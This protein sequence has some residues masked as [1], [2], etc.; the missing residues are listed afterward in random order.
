MIHRVQLLL[1]TTLMCL[2]FFLVRLYVSEKAAII[3]WLDA[4]INEFHLIFVWFVLGRRIFGIFHFI[5]KPNGPRRLSSMGSTESARSE[6]K[7]SRNKLITNCSTIT[8]RIT[9]HKKKIPDAFPK[10]MENHSTNFFVKRETIAS[11]QNNIINIYYCRDR[12]QNIESNNDFKVPNRNSELVFHET[13]N[14][15]A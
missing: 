12:T 5:F 9:R 13:L 1:L 6:S 8:G 4:F 10:P 14:A 3:S 15:I 11:Q 7:K 2:V